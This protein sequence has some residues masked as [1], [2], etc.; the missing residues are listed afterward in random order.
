MV[1]VIAAASLGGCGS[2][3]GAQD[4]GAPISRNT[5]E[6]Q[7][8][9][10]MAREDVDRD[11]A[12]AERLLCRA[13]GADAF[14]GPAHNNLGV[15]LL[16]GPEPRLYEAAQRFE[17][18]RK[19]M[20]GNPDPRVNLAMTLERAGQTD[21][22]LACYR[23]ALDVAPEHVPALQ[24]L[25]GILIRSGRTDETTQRALRIIAVQGTTEQWRQW[26]RLQA[27]KGGGG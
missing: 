3:G 6:A 23:S 14:F 9:T 25:A 7:R 10:D 16:R 27:A 13:I 17:W 4:A 2:A 15:L 5:A 11:P 8:L 21:E 1:V 18:A 24:G 20:P 26:A 22:A 12:A 19:M